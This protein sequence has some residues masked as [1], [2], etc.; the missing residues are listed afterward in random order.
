MCVE[1]RGV[2]ESPAGA[3]HR[4]GIQRSRG[5]RAREAWNVLAEALPT[6]IAQGVAA[7]R[8]EPDDWSMRQP[9]YH[10]VEVDRYAKLLHPLVRGTLAR[11]GKFDRAFLER[12]LALY[13][14][15]R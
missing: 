9:W 10:R 2:V 3:A 6:A 12:A 4:D 7:E 5:A 1:L 11:D 13:G 14:V 15:P 8:F